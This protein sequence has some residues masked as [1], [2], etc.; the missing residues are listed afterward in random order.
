VKKVGNL[1]QT[2]TRNMATTFDTL[3][4]AMAAAYAIQNRAA[5]NAVV[6][7]SGDGE[8]DD[9]GSTE[10]CPIPGVGEGCPCRL[11]DPAEPVEKESKQLVA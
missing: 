11:P 1:W 3:G 4:E 8:G 9:G 2:S 7:Q 5:N 6:S 10:G